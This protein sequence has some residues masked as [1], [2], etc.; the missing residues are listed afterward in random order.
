MATIANT[1]MEVEQS[2]IGQT[3]LVSIVI[4]CRQDKFLTTTKYYI[5]QQNVVVSIFDRK[6]TKAER[7]RR[8]S[9][10]K[11]IYFWTALLWFS[12]PKNGIL[13]LFYEFEKEF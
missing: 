12:E 5:E 7:G 9:K 3:T 4:L 2:T 13:S 11:R 1:E 10:A 6:L 8:P